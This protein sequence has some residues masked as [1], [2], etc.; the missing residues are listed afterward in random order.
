MIAGKYMGAIGSASTLWAKTGGKPPQP[1]V[2]PLVCH[3]LD[4]A[5]VALEVWDHALP[6]SLYELIGLVLGSESRST[7]GRVLAFWAGLHDI[8]K[9]A[10]GFQALYEAGMP[11]LKLAG[12]AF[13]RHTANRRHALLTGEILSRHFSGYGA[14]PAS[15]VARGLATAVAGHHGDFPSPVEQARLKTWDLGGAEWESARKSIITDLSHS[16]GVAEPVPPALSPREHS[17]FMFLAGLTSVSDWIG[18]SERWFP[19]E[20]Y[21]N[22]LDQYF[23]EAREKAA[24]AIAE[25]GWA[26]WQPS[27]EALDFRG[28]FGF[29]PNAMQEQVLSLESAKERGE[30]VIIEAPMGEGKTEAALALIDKWIGQKAGRGCYV[31]M[32]TQ[33][34]A[35]AMFD[36]FRCDYLTHR[37]P[38]QC[39][40]LQLL[41]GHA[42]LSAAYQQLRQLGQIWDQDDGRSPAGGAV[43]AGEW[44]GFRKR[45]LL[46]P[47]GVGTVDQALLSAM[48]A[49]HSFVRLFGLAGKA[50]IF[51]EVH[52][53]DT[54]TS[55]LLDRLLSWLAAL[56]CP[57]VLLSA[58][59]PPSRRRELV[60]AYAGDGSEAAEAPYPRLL[61]ATAGGIESKH[62]ASATRRVELGWL[63]RDPEALARYLDDA[64][65]HGGCAAVICNTVAAAQ[66]T[67]RA[68]Q[69]DLDDDMELNLFH[70]RFPFG[71]RDR[72]EKQAIS[73]FG[74]DG[75]RRAR[76]VLVATQV[77]EQS[78]DLDFDLM[79]SEVAPADLL[80]QRSGRMHRHVRERPV[81]L[82]TPRLVL[83]RPEMS[84]DG[85]PV[86]GNS[87]FIY[88]DYLLLRTWLALQGREGFSVPED[89]EDLICQVYEVET[90]GTTEALSE[91]LS[92]AE[93]KADHRRQQLE[94]EAAQRR[95]PSPDIDE[96]FW[97]LP[98]KLALDEDDPELHKHYR[99]LTRWEDRPSVEVICLELAEG[100]PCVRSQDGLRPVDLSAAPSEDLT[101]A[102]MLRSVRLSGRPASA[103]LQQDTPSGWRRNSLLRHH[104]AVVFDE[105]G[106]FTGD[107][108]D[109]R[110][111]PE[112]GIVIPHA[113]EGDE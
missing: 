33:A 92:A 84:E 11:S 83:I 111:D 9:A 63:D 51:D 104:R 10:P 23:A 87:S 14:S 49:P 99:A 38:N 7:S 37:Y 2:H 106:E 13:P 36:R 113:D 72:R 54:Y 18:S 53:F 46:G 15:A 29:T 6:S 107:G 80:L 78:L 56:G 93:E 82:E 26:R 110:L 55:K 60:Q 96:Q 21:P 39:V 1:P 77:I 41:H 61:R 24:R 12:F 58:T 57:V 67:F 103:L 73:Q 5:A 25:I 48:Q 45:G 34:T 31:A 16:L 4:V 64:L 91:A 69:A 108:F 85:V 68:L 75:A 88:G 8:G 22:D 52:A 79:V 94:H 3:L 44:F 112:L 17:F 35:N 105:A 95:L 97:A 47:F 102:L 74:K 59:L 71:E 101:E 20:R 86:F 76:S 42:C 19:F 50:V 109:L 40:D 81:G 98:A 70:A 62:W 89:V 43:V 30:L 100:E 32:P 65:Q 66:D 90:A 28:F 27:D